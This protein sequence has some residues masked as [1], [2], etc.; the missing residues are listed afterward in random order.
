[1]NP[2]FLNKKIIVPTKSQRDHPLVCQAMDMAACI[3]DLAFLIDGK[4][5]LFSA[6]F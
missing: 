3:F 6:C 2:I 5:L 4:H 1:M